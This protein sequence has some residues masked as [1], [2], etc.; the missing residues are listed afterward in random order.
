MIARRGEDASWP[1]SVV[2]HVVEPTANWACSGGNGD[3]VFGWDMTAFS[4]G[5]SRQGSCSEQVE[6]EIYITR[7]GSDLVGIMLNWM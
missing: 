6:S 5:M 3:F 4:G 7:Q 2:Y 1:L